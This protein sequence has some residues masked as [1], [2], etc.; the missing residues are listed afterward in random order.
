MKLQR[1][2]I[3]WSWALL[4]S[5]SSLMPPWSTQILSGGRFGP[6]SLSRQVSLSLPSSVHAWKSYARLW[7]SEGDS[8]RLQVIGKKTSTLYFC[9]LATSF[10]RVWI[11][12]FTKV[13][14]SEN[15]Q[16]KR[17]RIWL[18]P[19]ASF[20]WTCYNKSFLCTSQSISN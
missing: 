18:C 16:G 2:E 12:W 11:F 1:D 20:K 9:Y 4:F 6:M 3:R 13:V 5:L 8:F 10:Q 19:P 7:T 15:T 14:N 17:Q